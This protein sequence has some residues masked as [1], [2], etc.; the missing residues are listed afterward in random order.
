[1]KQSS[2]DQVVL[3]PAKQVRA[4]SVAGG[5]KWARA[6]RH[7]VALRVQVEFALVPR[8]RTQSHTTTAPPVPYQVEEEQHHK[9]EAGLRRA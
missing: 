5:W 4:R 2:T 9:E 6:G 1:M 3:V 7:E 8:S